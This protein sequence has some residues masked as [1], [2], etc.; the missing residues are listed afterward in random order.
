PCSSASSDL[1]GRGGGISDSDSHR[2]GSIGQCED[3]PR[4]DPFVS[5]SYRPANVIQSTFLVTLVRPACRSNMRKACPT[6]LNRPR[7]F[8]PPW[9]HGFGNV[10]RKGLVDAVGFEPTTSRV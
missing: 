6:L 1:P 3:A 8:V 4:V 5:T 2:F 9:S 10:V 7:F